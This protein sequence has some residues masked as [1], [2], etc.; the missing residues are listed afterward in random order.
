MLKIASLVLCAIFCLPS[1]ATEP[2]QVLK[3]FH[4]AMASG[5]SAAAS[6]L[7]ATDVTIYES[8]YVERSKAEYVAH[9]LPEDIK[10]A[11]SSKRSELASGERHSD[12]MV[13]IWTETQTQATV[14]GKAVRILGTETAV[15]QKTGDS[16]ALVH[17]HWSSRKPQ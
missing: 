2:Q 14:K 11:Q 15:L 6:A 5:D 16:W 4:A 3:A 1:F 9:H 13:V 17:I 7:L 10:F 12:N 8:G